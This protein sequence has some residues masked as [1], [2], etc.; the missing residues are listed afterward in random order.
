[1]P[2][3]KKPIEWVAQVRVAQAL[4]PADGT[5]PDV[6]LGRLQVLLA[7]VPHDSKRAVFTLSKPVAQAA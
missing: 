7:S 2:F 4:V 3:E 1:M 6:L 5:D